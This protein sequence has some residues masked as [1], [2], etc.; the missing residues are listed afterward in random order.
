MHV[1][2]VSPKWPSKP[3]PFSGSIV[4]CALVVTG[5]TLMGMMGPNTAACVLA[6]IGWIGIF[7]AWRWRNL[8]ERKAAA[9]GEPLAGTPHW[10]GVV[11]TLLVLSLLSGIDRHRCPHGRYYRF[12][13]FVAFRDDIGG[14]PCRN[15]IRGTRFELTQGWYLIVE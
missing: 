2:G 1:P 14:G 3:M 9:R 10:R 8:M 5:F 7:V 11:L 13:P 15:Y 6:A 4:L 12:G